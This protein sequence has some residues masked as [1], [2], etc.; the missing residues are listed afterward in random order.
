MDIFIWLNVKYK[1]TYTDKMG[2]IIS[3]KFYVYT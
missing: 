2:Y 1:N 3:Y